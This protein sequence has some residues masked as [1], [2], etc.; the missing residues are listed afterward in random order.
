MHTIIIFF[1]LVEKDAVNPR[2]LWN[3]V[4]PGLKNLTGRAKRHARP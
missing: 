3:Q 1:T 2:L 4:P